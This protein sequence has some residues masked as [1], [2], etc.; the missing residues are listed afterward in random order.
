ITQSASAL[1][2][3]QNIIRKIYFPRL[4]LPLSRAIV[5]IIE[6]IIGILLLI[7]A[8]FIFKTPL[9]WG[10]FMIIPTLFFT[11]LAALGCGLWVSTLSIQY[12]DLQQ[13]IPFALQILF[14]ASPIAYT[15]SFIENV[16]PKSYAFLLYLNPITGILETFRGVLF[17]HELSSYI[18]ISY[19]VATVIFISGVLLFQA[20]EKK[21][22]D[23]L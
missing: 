7:I 13:I 23:L 8:M 21:M 4:A 14:F 3:A 12:R 11:A 16:I 9:T 6:P 20:M 19:A 1:V 2:H 5:G 10:I 18:W 17:Q 22:A 15:S